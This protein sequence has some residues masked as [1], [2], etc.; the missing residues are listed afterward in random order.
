[1]LID[2]HTHLDDDAFKGDLDTVIG[3]SQAHSVH[4]W[5]NVGYNEE[6]WTSTIELA[7]RIEGMS[8]MLGVHPGNADDWDDCLE[9]KL[10]GLIQSHAPVAVGEIGMDLYW[11][12]DNMEHQVNAFRSQLAI[13]DEFGLPAVIHMRSAEEPLL[14]VLESTRTLP[15]IHFHSFDGGEELRSWILQQDAT[16]GVGGLMTRKGSEDLRD[17]IVRFPRDNVALETDSPY[18]KPRGVRGRRNEPAFL[19]TVARTLG[20]LWSEDV[21]VVASR[22]TQNAERIFGMTEVN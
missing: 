5:I 9:E 16:I 21:S 22:T 4:R 20:E 2:T 7:R 1:M 3:T 13:A 12:Q 11:R 15:R 6:R 8:M 10:R 14:R 18:L 17:W 19:R